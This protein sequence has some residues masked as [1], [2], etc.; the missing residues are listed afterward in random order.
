MRP[1]VVRLGNKLNRDLMSMVLKRKVLKSTPV[2]ASAL[3]FLGL[4][5]EV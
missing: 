4:P 2:S 3:V 5:V 1:G